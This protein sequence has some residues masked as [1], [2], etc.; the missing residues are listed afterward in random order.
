MRH[1]CN[2]WAVASLVCLLLACV[3]AAT[4]D[5]A[6]TSAVAAEVQP[7]RLGDTEVSLVVT[8]YGAGGYT[9]VAIHEN[10]STAVAA[11]RTV[12]ARYGGRLIQLKHGGTR[13][14]SFKLGGRAYSIDP[15]RIFTDAGIRATVR[16]GYSPEVH[17]AVKAFAAEIIKRLEGSRAIVALHNN[18]NGSYSI[19]QYQGRGPL[20]ADAAEVHV[21]EAQDPDDFFFVTSRRLFAVIKAGGFNVALQSASVS[22]DGSLS[23]YSARHGI[24]YV[25]VE[26]ENGHQAAQ[27]KMLDALL[28]P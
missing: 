18:T 21:V 25:N 16:G 23:V 4:L 13:N 19:R 14:V 6:V 10:E 11:A 22:D 24:M 28:A 7:V 9:F 2:A 12:L 1:Y 5:M 8:R 15:N 20:A 17:Q 27:T 3:P 26:A